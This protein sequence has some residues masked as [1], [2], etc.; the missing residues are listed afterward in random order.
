[1]RPSDVSYLSV[2]TDT[3]CYLNKKPLPAPFAYHTYSHS[4]PQ[5]YKH[6]HTVTPRVAICK[7]TVLCAQPHWIITL[8]L[9]F[10]FCQ[11]SNERKLIWN[12]PCMNA[13]KCLSNCEIVSVRVGM[14]VCVLTQPTRNRMHLNEISCMRELMH[15]LC[16]ECSKRCCKC[17]CKH[18][19][20][21]RIAGRVSV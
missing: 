2:P 1:M 15:K 18:K 19:S 9:H 6:T 4:A 8:G 20:Q 16:S 17:K 10:G 12:C 3:N 5:R 13:W 7:A 21:S 11:N 14:R